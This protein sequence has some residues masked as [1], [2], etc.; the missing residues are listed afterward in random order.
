MQFADIEAIVQEVRQGGARE[1]RL[2]WS[3]VMP[4]LIE[5]FRE[6]FQRQAGVCA[7]S[8]SAKLLT[9]AAAATKI[10][11][12]RPSEQQRCNRA[13]PARKTVSADRGLP[14]PRG[15]FLGSTVC[16]PS[17]RPALAAPLKNTVSANAAG[18]FRGKMHGRESETTFP[19]GC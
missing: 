6:Q 11:L 4:L 2:A 18:A 13:E 19:T 7:G 16:L 1:P 12:I 5:P 8:E 10:D 15:V 17:V 9:S 3:E 14:G